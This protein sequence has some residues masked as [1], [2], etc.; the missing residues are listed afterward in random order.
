MF[1][2]DPVTCFCLTQ[3]HVSVSPSHMFLSHPV[4]CFCLTQSHVSVSPSHNFLSHPVACFCLTQSHASVSPSHMFLSHPVTCFCLT[5]SHVSV[6]PSHMLVYLRN[7]SAQ[8]RV[9][10]DTLRYKLQIYLTH[11]QYTDTCPTSPSTDRKTPGLWQG[12]R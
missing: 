5:Q 10:A 6:S 7:G 9:R 2:S 4:T 11:S 1:L 8:T 3:S 12:S